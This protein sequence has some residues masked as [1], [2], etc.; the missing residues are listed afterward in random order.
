MKSTSIS[1]AL[2]FA[3]AATLCGCDRTETTGS[4]ASDGSSAAPLRGTSGY[5]PYDSFSMLWTRMGQN[6][7]MVWVNS[8]GDAG[9][10]LVSR[11]TRENR[12]DWAFCTQGVVA[13]LAARGEEVVI[14]AT[15]YVSD[16]A[17]LPVYRK[18]RPKMK[19]ARSL[20][21]P[22]SSIEFAFDQLLQR[23][24]VPRASVRIP[25]VEKIDFA[26]IASLLSK[27]VTDPDALDFAILVDPAITNLLTEQ[28]TEYQVGEGGLYEMH[29]SLVVR[30]EDLAKRRDAFVRL[31]REFVEI[32]KKLEEVKTEDQFHHEIWG[33]TKDGTPERLPKMMTFKREPLRLQLRPTVLR[34][35][36]QTE[37]VYLTEKYPNQLAMPDDVDRLVDPSLLR[38]VASSKVQK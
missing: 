29:Y 8:G 27:P 28:P 16:D 38:E 36:L 33:R 14:I 24:K 19:G 7:T 5:T 30:R 35:R 3:I 13:G 4:E 2:A 15:T 17:I 32:D 25:K 20:F 31:L 37:L 34:S 26:T 22:R 12:P 18:P 21:I 23:E 11:A 1:Y 9:R 10:L 6:R